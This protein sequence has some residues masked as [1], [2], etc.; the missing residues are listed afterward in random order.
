MR[1]DE[2]KRF[3]TS[4]RGEGERVQHKHTRRGGEGVQ[5]Q[6]MLKT[7]LKRKLDSTRNPR[8]SGRNFVHL[9]FN[10]AEQGSVQMVALSEHMQSFV[11]MILVGSQKKIA[12]AQH[13]L[14]G[15]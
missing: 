4:T 1:S 2:V 3:S 9:Q 15:R 10:V 8:A 5:G 11:W 12:F 7:E 14:L 13:T 6:P